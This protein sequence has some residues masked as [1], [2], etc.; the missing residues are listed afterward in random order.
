MRKKVFAC[1]QIFFIFGVFA[2]VGYTQSMEKT[3]QTIKDKTNIEWKNN[4]LNLQESQGITINHCQITLERVTVFKSG[5]KAVQKIVIP[6]DQIDS[7]RI[8]AIQ[9]ISNE[10]IY[11]ILLHSKNNS[12]VIEV[13]DFIDGK[14]EGDTFET[15]SA[16][17]YSYDIKEKDE[18]INTLKHLFQLCNNN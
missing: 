12:N 8:D 4:E 5:K 15:D 7:A 10:N 17:I 6:V 16:P 1:L 18:L 2:S 14:Q 13:I 9:S 11:S 3:I